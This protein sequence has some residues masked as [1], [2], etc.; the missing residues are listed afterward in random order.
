MCSAPPPCYTWRPSSRRRRS[1]SCR[2][3]SRWRWGARGRIRAVEEGT[4]G[5]ARPR[6]CLGRE[7]GS[8]P[9]SSWVAP[10]RHAASCG[11]EEEAPVVHAS[12]VGGW[13]KERRSRTPFASAPRG[14]GREEAHRVDAAPSLVWEW[15]A[16]WV[17]VACPRCAGRCPAAR[18]WAQA[19]GGGCGCGPRLAALLL[20][21]LNLC[22][23]RSLSRRD[24]G[25]KGQIPEQRGGRAAMDDAERSSG[26]RR[27]GRV[28][29]G[30]CGCEP[31]LA[32]PLLCPVDMRR[33][34]SLREGGREGRGG[35]ERR[36]K[37][38]W[39][40]TLMPTNLGHSP[41]RG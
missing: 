3:C 36:A 4:E 39:E 5:A 34:R 20:Y 33:H 22:R 24:E 12:G 14:W 28:S 7:L 8:S 38:D 23:R 11:E 35:E 13:S 16:T 25:G 9:L 32:A 31:R 15:W 2:S 21:P 40:K 29:G 27:G 30:G 37:R 6:D 10:G 18:D 17:R 19:P 1:G 41:N 26:Q